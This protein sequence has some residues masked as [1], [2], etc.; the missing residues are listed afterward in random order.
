MI[1]VVNIGLPLLHTGVSA[2]IFINQRPPAVRGPDPFQEAASYS[3][4]C[5]W[6]LIYRYDDYE[7]HR[8]LE[9]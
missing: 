4:L 1:R 2:E 3:L 5:W 9:C 8:H 7:P 6:S